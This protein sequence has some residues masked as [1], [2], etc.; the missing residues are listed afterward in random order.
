MLPA[1]VIFDC[2]GTLEDSEHLGN[3]VFAAMLAAQGL[4]ITGRDAMVR[5]RGMKLAESLAQI[6]AELGRELPST[7][8]AEFRERTAKAFRDELKPVPGAM[9]LVAALNI[10]MCVASSGPREKI[11]LSLSLTGLLPFFTGR[12]FSSYEVGSWKPDPGLFLHA[13]KAMAVEP[14]RCV[15]VEDSLPGIQAGIAAGMTVFAFQPDA[16]D[17]RIPA[18]VSVV[19]SLPQLQA[20]FQS[21]SAGEPLGKLGNTGTAPG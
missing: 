15:V 3:D 6:E 9:T 18:G 2:D 21:W 16:I 5:F 10:P 14:S 12:I 20:L 11:E 19:Q 8:V 7:F 17:A 13:A 4:Q 1:A